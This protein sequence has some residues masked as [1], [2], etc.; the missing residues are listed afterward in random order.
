M[1]ID[2]QQRPFFDKC[3]SAVNPRRTWLA[4]GTLGCLW[5][6]SALAQAADDSYSGDVW[7]GQWLAEGT[8]FSLELQASG[9]RFQLLPRTPAGLQWQASEGRINGNSATVDVHYQGVSATVL[10]QLQSPLSAI[11]RPMSC[12]PDYHVI[13]TLVS[14][15]QARFIKL[16]GSD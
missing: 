13:C 3:L 14:N 6:L 2:M 7:H 4:I 9:D 1:E 16:E 8:L 11:V 10:V 12:Q 5:L 15:Q